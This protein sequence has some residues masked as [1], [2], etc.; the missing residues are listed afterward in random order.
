MLSRDEIKEAVDLNF[1]NYIY[2]CITSGELMRL[3]DLEMRARREQAEE[4]KATYERDAR[5]FREECIA[6]TLKGCFQLFGSEA[7]TTAQVIEH[8]S[9][10]DEM[11]DCLTHLTTS[12]ID[13]D[14]LANTLDSLCGRIVNGMRFT[15]RS[16]DQ[17]CVEL[18]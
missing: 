14:S 17:W 7:F 10:D 5:E 13:P 16:L 15:R 4:L 6:W 9:K 11:M 12:Q 1:L 2:E 18:I 8:G 3:R